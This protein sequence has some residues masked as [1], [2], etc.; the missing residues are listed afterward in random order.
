[1]THILFTDKASNISKTSPEENTNHSSNSRSHL[2]N[3]M[4]NTCGAVPIH[5]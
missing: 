4:K 1:V 2:G 3:I 5:F